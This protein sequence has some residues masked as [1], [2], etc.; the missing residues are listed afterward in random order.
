[1]R[2]VQFLVF[3]FAACKSLCC[4]GVRHQKSWKLL[5]SCPVVMIPQIVEWNKGAVALVRPVTSVSVRHQKQTLTIHRICQ[6]TSIEWWEIRLVPYLGVLVLW[7]VAFVHVVAIVVATSWYEQMV[8]PG[9][10]KKNHQTPTRLTTPK[11]WLQ[12][13]VVHL[14]LFFGLIL[15]IGK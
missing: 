8:P 5:P 2:S 6:S 11:F 9:P 14:Q 1:M 12:K 7:F 10:P 15:T 4:C 3:M 13:S